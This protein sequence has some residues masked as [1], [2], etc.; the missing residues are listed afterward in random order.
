MSTRSV[1]IRISTPQ[2]QRPTPELVK[3]KP[4]PQSMKALRLGFWTPGLLLAAVQAWTS[5]YQVT[6]DSISYLDM[7]DGVFRG[8]DWH[9]LI[10]GVWSPLYPFL[11][12]LFRRIFN[13]SAPNEMAGHLLNIAFFLFAFVC[14]EF[15]LQTAIN[16][17]AAR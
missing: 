7:R 4:R 1:P 14:F 8:Y 16:R 6:A 12:G 9:R 3:S 13:I 2:P 5:R 11:L 17:F 10:N 15:F